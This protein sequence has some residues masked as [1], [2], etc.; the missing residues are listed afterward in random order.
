V[1]PFPPFHPPVDLLGAEFTV[2]HDNFIPNVQIHSRGRLPHWQADHALY[3]ITFRLRDSLRRDVMLNLVRER[4]TLLRTIDNSIERARLEAAFTLRL[5]RALDRH[6]GSCLLREH[7]ELAAD[8]LRHFDG[9]RYELHAWC[10]MPNHVHVLLRLA[11][12]DDLPRVVHSWKSW[13]AHEIGRGVI[14]Q[15]EYFDRLIRGARDYAQTVAYI[16]NNP[17]KAGLVEWPWMG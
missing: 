4:E 1:I 6:Y 10:V 7:A 15:R 3:F 9:G 2:R 5:D 11:N 14:W 16:R 8:A 12:G 17:K 13:I